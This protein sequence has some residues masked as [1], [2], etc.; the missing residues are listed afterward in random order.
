MLIDRTGAQPTVL[1]GR[2]H[3]MIGRRSGETYR[4]GDSVIVKL[5]EAAPVAGALRFELVSDGR[6]DGPRRSSYQDERQH[7]RRNKDGRREDRSKGGKRKK[8]RK[9]KGKRRAS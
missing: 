9:N 3:A 8:Q 6:F 7:Y 1:M 2:R 5:I 4:L